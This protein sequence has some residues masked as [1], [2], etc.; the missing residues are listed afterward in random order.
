MCYPYE[1]S[2]LACSPRDSLTQFASSPVPIKTSFQD[3]YSH[4]PL[5]DHSLGEWKGLCNSMKLWTMLCR[6]TQDRQWRVLRKCS[7]LEDEMVTHSSTL[8]LK[9]SWTV[10]KSEK[11]WHQKM[12][13]PRLESV[14]YTTGEEQKAITN[15]SRKN[16]AAGSKREQCSVVD[17]S[18]GESKAKCCKEQYCIETKMLGPWIKVNWT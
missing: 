18:G 11:I 9:I 4:L 3:C 14:Q 17:V 15:R 1:Q 16:E 2:W 13:T 12:S 10:W 5:H 6:A 7:P 8:V